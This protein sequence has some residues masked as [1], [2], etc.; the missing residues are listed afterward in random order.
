MTICEAVA[1]AVAIDGYITTPEFNGKMKIKPT[2]S[3]RCCI[4]MF[5]DGSHPSK[6]GWNCRAKD[7]LRDDWLV[8]TKDQ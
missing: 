2:D 5:W 3:E 7:L 6:Y 4:L 1:K 8:I